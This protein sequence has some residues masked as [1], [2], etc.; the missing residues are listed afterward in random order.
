M[1]V[2]RGLVLLA[3]VIGFACP[4]AAQGVPLSLL[5]GHFTEPPP[6]KSSPASP[7]LE[8]P[9][10]MAPKAAAKIALHIDSIV[11]DGSTVYSDADLRPLFVNMIGRDVSAADIYGL[12]A[13]ISARYG[14]DGYL[15]AR[16]VVVPQSVDAKAAT[17]HIHI[18][19]GYIEDIEWPP[20]ASRYRDLFTPCLDKIKSERPARTKTLERC[21]LLFNDLPGLKFTSTLKA[22]RNT[23]GGI[24]LAVN[25]TE[26]PVD[27]MARVD[28]RGIPGRGPW[29]FLGSATENNLL[30][31][32][33]SFNFTYAGA[34]D[35]SELQYFSGTYHQ[36]LLPN[37][38]YFEATAYGS[39]GTPN[40]PATSFINY[41]TN[42]NG[43]EG[44]FTYPVIRSREQN[45]SASALFFAEQDDSDAIGSP[46]TDDR[47]RGI[48]ARANYDQV[49]TWFGTVGQ[50]QIIATFSQGFDGLGSTSNDNPMASIAGGQVDFS[51]IETLANR[52]QALAYGFSL[53]G[54]VYAQWA[55]S[56]LLVPEECGYGGSYFGRAFD[57]FEFAGDRCL[58]ELGELR[59]DPVI[60]HNPLTQNQFYGFADH[61]DVS[62]VA[63][64]PGTPQNLSGSS[65]G[66]GLRLAWKA[67]PNS[68]IDT[69]NLDLQ[70]AH[71]LEGGTDDA[72]RFF[73][74]LV[75]KY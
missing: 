6:I 41:R 25:L 1:G 56:T 53:Y 31:L 34:F 7:F 57:L 67:D 29:E 44:G 37:G 68:A 66:T 19:E 15:L 65:V 52:T 43:I 18:V 14:Q 58:E 48:R 62:R 72:W 55:G 50:S 20:E 2:G 24:I 51:K 63:A 21:L 23:D 8:M 49:D 33:E 39:L 71:S 12:A 46:L 13:K 38:L 27:A 40:L 22:G 64:V 30:R 9:E 74:M 42:S 4:A 26:K 16:A 5:P 28:N 75:A 35:L 32:Q 60:P 47:L 3:W 61:G 54:A 70:G 73:L 11:V 59:F 10:T 17:I 36:N 69:F 45:L